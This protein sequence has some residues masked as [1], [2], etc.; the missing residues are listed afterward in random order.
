M[1]VTVTFLVHVVQPQWILESLDLVTPG[2]P[3]FTVL[4]PAD[5]ALIPFVV[6][7]LPA[8][9]RVLRGWPPSVPLWIGV[10]LVIGGL[11]SLAVHPSLRGCLVVYRLAGGLGLIWAISKFTKEEFIRN[12]ALPAMIIAGIEGALAVAQL[13]TDRALLPAWTGANAPVITDGVARA[14]GTLGYAY[15]ASTFALI[16]VGLGIAAYRTVP[17]R[18]RRWWPVILAFAAIP[19][20]VSFSR[21]ALLGAVA[22][23][24]T[25]LWGMVRETPEWRVVL[26]AFT[27]G[28]AVPA[29]FFWSSWTP[30]VDQSLAGAEGSGANV[31]YEQVEQAWSLI[32]VDWIIGVGPGL[33]SATLEERMD[34]DP[35]RAYPVH[36]LALYVAAEDGAVV[37]GLLVLMFIGL[38]VNA[39]RRSTE[40]RTLFI[41]PIAVALFDVLL[42]VA[43]AGLL[44]LAWWLGGL[45]ALESRPEL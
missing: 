18:W 5:F 43:P 19:I 21:G 35:E 8:L 6:M 7:A 25:L 4:N 16:A 23:V 9:R 34:L 40:N 44:M 45:A 32:E 30:R 1:L 14:A 36:N 33:Y 20:A 17:F 37:G 42:Y 41:A 24:V 13:V 38:A 11:A 12:L 22:I 15:K 3:R 27:I 2:H 28:L 29:A 10:L 26:A 31:R 39:G